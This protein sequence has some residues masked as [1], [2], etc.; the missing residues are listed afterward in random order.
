L[1]AIQFLASCGTVNIRN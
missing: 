1:G